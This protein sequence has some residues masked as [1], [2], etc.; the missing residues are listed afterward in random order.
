MA[1]IPN[2][3]DDFFSEEKKAVSIDKTLEEKFAEERHK[4]VTKIQ[5][6]SSKL[7]NILEIQELMVNIYTDRQM[8][9]EYYHML[10]SLLI[11]VN[12]E[13]RS[14]YTKRYEHYSFNS[15]KRFPNEKSKEHQI[16][17]EMED[18]INK[19]ESMNN[20]LKYMENTVKTLDNIIYGMKYR[21]EIEQI[22]RGK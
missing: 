12:K 11:K 6:M 8:A 7:K 5:G 3:F 17:S 16:L 1:E 10:L 20:M 15:Q 9:I 14:Q 18:I 4:W 13:Y 22:S 19:K 21:I 2:S